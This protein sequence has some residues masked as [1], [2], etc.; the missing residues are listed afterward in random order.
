[1][2]GPRRCSLE[3]GRSRRGRGA[4]QG[5]EQAGES[6]VREGNEDEV[7]CEEEVI[8]DGGAYFGRYRCTTMRSLMLPSARTAPALSA[9]ARLK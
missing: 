9:A 1:M 3:R 2:A 5:L 6:D 8:L 4:L 7:A